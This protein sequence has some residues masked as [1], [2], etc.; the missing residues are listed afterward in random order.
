MTGWVLQAMQMD[1]LNQYPSIQ[2]P[3]VE[4]TGYVSTDGA[5]SGGS[6]YDF[7]VFSI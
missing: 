6:D 3:P 4:T 7:Y 2:T 1:P 5:K